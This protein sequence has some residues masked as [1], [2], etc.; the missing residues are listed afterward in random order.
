[1]NIDSFDLL[2]WLL[3]KKRYKCTRCNYPLFKTDDNCPN[4]GQPINWGDI[5]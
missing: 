5:L 4:C 2:R 1:M 3:Q